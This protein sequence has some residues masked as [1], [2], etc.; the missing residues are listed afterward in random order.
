M[1]SATWSFVRFTP[2]GEVPSIHGCAALSTSPV[3]QALTRGCM[4]VAGVGPT[5]WGHACEPKHTEGSGVS[6][7][8]ARGYMALAKGW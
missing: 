1:V 2:I 5:G 8:E 6:E 3:S 7:T 4:Q